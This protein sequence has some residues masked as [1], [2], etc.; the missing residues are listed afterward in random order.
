[1]VIWLHPDGNQTMSIR[2]TVPIR[3]KHMQYN[4]LWYALDVELS[5]MLERERE[6]ETDQKDE[7]RENTEQQPHPPSTHTPKNTQKYN[8]HLFPLHQNIRFTSLH[9]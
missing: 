4:T 2:D 8:T 5:A 3:L 7:D 9:L 6:T 1:M